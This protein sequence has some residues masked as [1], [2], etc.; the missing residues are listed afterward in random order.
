MRKLDML[1][2]AG[3][4]Y[5]VTMGQNEFLI[6]RRRAGIIL[7]KL[8]SAKRAV[9]QRHGNGL[10]LLLAENQSITTGELWRFGL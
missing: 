8:A 1:D 9:H 4:L 10:A 2:E 3:G 7:A 6:L 5:V